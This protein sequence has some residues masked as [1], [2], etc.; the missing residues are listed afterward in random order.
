MSDSLWF[1]RKEDMSP[2]G[3]LALICQPDGDVIV[4]VIPGEDNE[5]LGL[6]SVE[7]C[8]VG[9]GGGKSPHTLRALRELARAIDRDNRGVE[10]QHEFPW[11][12]WEDCP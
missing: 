1:N 9:G 3:S 11:Q 8:S 5:R 10:F 7:F 12:G 4:R 6:S 2:D